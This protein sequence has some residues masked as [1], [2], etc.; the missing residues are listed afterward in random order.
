MFSQRN[1]FKNALFRAPHYEFEDIITQI[2]S[3]EIL[4]P[5]LDL[6]NRRH[7][8]AKRVAYHAPIALNPGIPEIK[9]NGHYDLFLAICGA[10]QDL[11]MVNAVKNWRDVCSTSIC[12]IDEI[13]VKQMD[14]CRHFLG[15]LKRF[16]IVMLYYSQSVRPL[17]EIIERKCI[18]MPPGVDAF[19]F[20]PYPELPKRVVDVYSI[21]RRSEVTH[22]QL[23]SLSGSGKMFYVY[24]TV[25]GD[26]AINLKEHRSILANITKRSRYFIVNPGLIDRPD[27]RGNQLEIG[28]RYFEGAAAGSIM[29]GEQ[30]KNG[31]FEKLFDWPDAVIQLPYGSGAIEAIIAEIEREP[32]R[33]SQIRKTNVVQ[34]L[35]RHDWAY[36]WEAMLKTIGLEPTPELFQRKVCL[37][38]LAESVN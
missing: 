4:A 2:D 9:I 17:S 31:E 1:I 21:G 30:P 3:A 36:R 27:K 33:Q 16:D 37:R 23:L 13:W 24:D 19:L 29:I 11:L 26:Q 20:G 32:E 5:Q 12:L 38:K 18:F 22:K 25:A 8:L 14:G 15:I 28:N 7:E 34:A 35:M 10:P 6:S